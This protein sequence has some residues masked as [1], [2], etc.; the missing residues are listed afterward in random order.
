MAMSEEAKARMSAAMKGKTRSAE[1]I[2]KMSSTM[3]G[4]R[5]SEETKAKMSATR[6]ANGGVKTFMGCDNPTQ[7]NTVYKIT[8]TQNG[9]TYVGST[10]RMLKI[11]AHEHRKQLRFNKHGNKL[12]QE[13]WNKHGENNFVLKILEIVLPLEDLRLRETYWLEI[14]KPEY[15]ETYDA[16]GGHGPKTEEQKQ[17]MSNIMTGRPRSENA[18]ANIKLGWIKRKNKENETSAI[19]V[20]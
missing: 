12:F 20:G 9:N 17:Y 4:K 16:R 10:H 19:S 3:L 6:I 7:E 18:K 5:L 11:R 13:D 1:T 2:A 8:C 14:L 15:N